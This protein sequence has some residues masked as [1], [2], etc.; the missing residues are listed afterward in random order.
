MKNILLVNDTSLT[1]HHG[2]S[3]LMN[4]IYDLFK[5]NNLNI[6]NKNIFGAKYFRFC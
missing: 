3:L 4:S 6:K 1:C 5:K 2:C